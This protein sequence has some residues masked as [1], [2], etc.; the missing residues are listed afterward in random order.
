MWSITATHPI[1][2]IFLYQYHASL[3]LSGSCDSHGSFGRSDPVTKPY[4][5]LPYAPMA[6]LCFQTITYCYRAS[7]C[8]G[9]VD[10][11]GLDLESGGL[12][13]VTKHYQGFNLALPRPRERFT[14]P[15]SADD[16][17]T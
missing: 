4:H 14:S 3:V 6:I 15:A 7:A 8:D 2:R 5:P 10:Q 1:L 12:P 13:I 11:V 9:T 17:N 16:G